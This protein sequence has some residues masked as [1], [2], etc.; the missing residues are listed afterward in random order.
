MTLEPVLSKLE[1]FILYETQ[2]FMY[3]VGCDKL[4]VEYRMLKLDR[5]VVHPA[6]LSEV[7]SED[8]CVYTKEELKDMLVSWAGGGGIDG[9]TPLT[10]ASDSPGDDP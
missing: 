6:S 3:V 2:A 5:Q 1:K 10:A 7:V 4:Q 9:K 8:E